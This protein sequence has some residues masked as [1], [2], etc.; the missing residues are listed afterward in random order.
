LK[1]SLELVFIE[2]PHKVLEA[3]RASKRTIWPNSPIDVSCI[4]AELR[5]T[6]RFLAQDGDGNISNS[7]AATAL[8]RRRRTI[9]LTVI[10]IGR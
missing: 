7:F 1:G 9:P 4:G 5:F 8:R 10:W 3:Y 6:Y 2:F